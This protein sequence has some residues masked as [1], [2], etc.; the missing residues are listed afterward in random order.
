MPSVIVDSDFMSLD[1]AVRGLEFPDQIR[2]TLELVTVDYHSFDDLLHR[3]QIVIHRD[4]AEDVEGLFGSFI[5]IG[6]PVFLVV[7]IVAFGWNDDES[8]AANNSSA[9]NYR[10]IKGTD[11]LSNHSFGTALD[12]NPRQNPYYARDGKVY[13]EGARYDLSV[14]G[15]V[16]PEVVALFKQRG[17]TW[18]GDWRIPV[19]YQHF[20]RWV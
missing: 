1:A 6:F 19:D 7:P 14:P 2:E 3:G 16:T 20:E 4:L 11:R 17:W 10:L 13:P 15:T 5:D 18:G 9:F 12:L 8:M